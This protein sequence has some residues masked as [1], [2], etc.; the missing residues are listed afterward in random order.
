[1]RTQLSSSWKRILKRVD[2]M[3]ESQRMIE[4]GLQS[5]SQENKQSRN[6]GSLPASSTEYVNLLEKLQNEERNLAFDTAAIANASATERHAAA[7]L[8]N[9]RQQERERLKPVL[10]D[11]FLANIDHINNGSDLMHV[12]RR[13]PKGAHLHCHFNTCLHPSFLIGEARDI[14][15]M[16]IRCTSSLA[17]QEDFKTAFVSFSVL[18][19]DTESSD[20]FDPV[21]E[22]LSW[23]RYSHFREKFPAEKLGDV[24]AWLARKAIINVQDAHAPNQTIDGVWDLFNRSTQMMKGLFNYESAFRNYIG[25]AI[26][27]FLDDGIMYAEV[28]PNFFDKSIPSDDG[29]RQLDHRAWMVIIR[30]EVAKKMKE[31]DEVGKGGHFRGIKVI[32][33]APRS[34]KKEDM[35]WCLNDC[36]ALKQEFPDLICGF[37][38]VGC[39]GRGNPIRFYID[40]LLQFRSDCI[41]LCLDIPFIF[42]AGET[43]ESGSSTD[44]NLFDAILLDSKRIGHGY[45]LPRHPKL[46]ELC[47]ERGIA[48]EICPISNEV[49]HLCSSIQ[50]HVLPTLLA[51]SVPCTINSDNP[52]YFSSSLS[53]DFYQ[54]MFAF[55]SMTLFGWKVLAEW[56]IEHSCLETEE[57]N[58]AQNFWSQEW[59]SFCQWIIDEY[60]SRYDN[61]QKEAS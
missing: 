56:S 34:I 5:S 59:V 1:M 48:L 2:S 33:C 12:S 57:K 38:M 16:F 27:S 45:A 32:Y 24:E 29:E 61:G 30:E 4:N 51:N 36:I 13:L 28:R 19:D 46:M 17:S 6:H 20:I 52:A 53:H 40:E 54:V 39:E 55:D 50:G 49:L 15:C 10:S 42:H 8:E 41:S 7:I 35:T 31:L 43:L 37:D 9:I 47:R 23:M 44:N 11:H 21:Y 22:P 58:K 25:E 3:V 18:R 60:G 14:K 26:Q